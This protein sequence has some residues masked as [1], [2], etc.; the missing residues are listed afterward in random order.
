MNNLPASSSKNDLCF[1]EGFLKLSYFL[2]YFLWSLTFTLR[3]SLYENTGGFKRI[4]YSEIIQFLTNTERAE[5]LQ[6]FRDSL[7]PI[8]M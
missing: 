7:E 8:R 3:Y 1:L 6:C 5:K 4:S 2:G